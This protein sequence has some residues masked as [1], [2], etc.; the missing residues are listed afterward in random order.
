MGR[1]Y[2]EIARGIAP[3]HTGERI[4]A[5]P[6]AAAVRAELHRLLAS[7]EFSKAKR[8]ARFLQFLVERTI[9]GQGETLK[10][11]V[12]AL[13]VFDRDQTFDP[14]IDSLVRVEAAR[15]L[16]PAQRL[17]RESR[18]QRASD[19]TAGRILHSGLSRAGR[20]D[21]AESREPRSTRA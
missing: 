20:A 6:S 8:A 19:R 14:R 10:E 9:E 7:P 11:Y 2:G 12:I 16:A 1:Y 13:E 5:G 15:L 17:L 3:V 21:M 4:R 18:S